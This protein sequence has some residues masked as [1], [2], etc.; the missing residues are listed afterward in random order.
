TQPRVLDLNVVVADI[1]RMLRRVI[2][3]DIDLVTG[4]DSSLGSTKADLGQLEQV[5]MNLAVNARDAMPEGGT[6]TIETANMD[7]QEALSV[8]NAAVPPGSYVMLAMTDTGIGM[9]TETQD[10]IFEPF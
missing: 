10:R 3:E 7:L 8:R 6:L 1:D 5:I 9:D 2:G 4:L